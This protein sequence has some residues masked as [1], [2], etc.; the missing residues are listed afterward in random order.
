MKI[1]NGK[2]TMDDEIIA[3]DTEKPTI[4]IVNLAMKN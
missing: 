2:L 3:M 1:D 4:Y